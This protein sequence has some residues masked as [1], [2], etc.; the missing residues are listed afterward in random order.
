MAGLRPLAIDFTPR[1][2][3][4]KR[5]GWLASSAGALLV[6]AAGIVWLPPAQVEASHMAVAPQHALLGVETAQAVAAAVRELNLPW[7]DVFDAMGASF[8]PAAD[9]VLLHVET[10][11]RRAVVRLAGE[12]R[13]AAT[14]Q[15]L[16]E[17]LRVLPSIDTATLVGQEARPGMLTHPVH[18]VIELQLR[19]RT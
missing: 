1:R 8:G 18:F 11:A 9:A 17:R 14:V 19:E 10:D 16:P 7:L 2:K 3:A 6:L 12:A 13:D 5:T 15:G 4:V